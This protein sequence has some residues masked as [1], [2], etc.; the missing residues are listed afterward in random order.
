[1]SSGFTPPVR[2]TKMM[3]HAS[4]QYETKDDPETMSPERLFAATDEPD[5]MINPTY[6][7][8]LHIH[9]NGIRLLLS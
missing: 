6:A 9:N 4:T 7:D 1:M 8:F 2:K 3:K 5:E